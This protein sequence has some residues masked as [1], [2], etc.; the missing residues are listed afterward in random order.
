MH[1]ETAL[2]R[3]RTAPPR[4]P[5]AALA[6]LT[7][8]AFG[9]VTVELM[10]SGLLP[11]IG[12]D[13]GVD[14]GA[15]G[16]L[17]GAWAIT[18]AVTA[19]PLVRLT[20]RIPRVRLLGG[21]AAVVA[22]VA[23]LT[24]WAP[25]YDWLVAGRV[26]SAAAHGVFWAVLVPTVA[27]LVPAERLG[28]ALSFVL[29]GPTLAGLVGLPAVAAL[30][31][32]IGW[33]AVSGFLAIL[34]AAAV[35]GVHHTLRSVTTRT[36]PS[37][38]PARFDRSAVPVGLLALA[39]GLVLVGHFAAFT[40]VT[41][42]V[43]RLGGLGSGAVPA[44]LLLFGAAGAVGVAL[45]GPLADRVPR[46]ALVGTAL[47]VA[48]GL[49]LLMLGSGRS[50]IFCLGVGVWGV[51][52]GAFPPILQAAVLRASSVRFRPL[53]GGVLVVVLN[54]GIAL[55]AWAGGALLGGG[56]AQLAL[57]ALL[58]AGAGALALA[59]ALTADRGGTS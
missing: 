21:A 29:A 10:P 7:A 32:A 34:L 38:G 42:L 31:S 20:A 39:G 12:R 9:T 1:S 47:G 14:P 8:A 54:A 53:A 28:R 19:L 58:A 26:L 48:F 3:T 17:V 23:L 16:A 35:L 56:V 43:V 15:V 13:F 25:A 55:G 33:R 36:A 51:A 59:G 24:A 49:L 18:V 4:L 41:A 45:A 37:E 30:A 40:Y 5:W 27:G 2:D 57:A 52:V 22:V 46:A 44:V 50:A 6:A 11:E